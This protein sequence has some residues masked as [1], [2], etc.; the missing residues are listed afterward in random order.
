MTVFNE[1]QQEQLK[2]IT[3]RLRTIRQEQHISLEEIAI[4]THIRLA[5]LQ[6][7]E[8][9]RFEDLPEPVFVQGFIRRYADKLGLDGTALANSFEVNIFPPAPH[10][11][12][13]PFS[14]YVPLFIPYIVL[15]IAAVVGLFYLLKIE[16]PGKSLAKKQNPILSVQQKNL[17]SPSSSVNL[18]T[19]TITP[20]ATT[21]P[22][23]TITPLADV[24]VSLELQGDSWV[25]VKADGKTEFEGI[26]TNGKQ[27]KWTAKKSLTVRAGNAGAVLVSVNEQE[28][29]LLGKQGQVKEFTYNKQ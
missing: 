2:E 12:T 9:W 4:Q 22:T 25:Q 7:L 17:S 6:A 28:P 27:K 23:P 13:P 1:C 15:L 24:I 14:L 3:A 16:F 19:P 10:P 20:L 8:E 21:A 18:S 26:L 11:S 29:K 5:F